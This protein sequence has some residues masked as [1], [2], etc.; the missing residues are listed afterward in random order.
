MCMRGIVHCFVD[1]DLKSTCSFLS[2]QKLFLNH[3]K[4]PLCICCNYFGCF[5]LFC[6]V[7]HNKAASYQIN[8]CDWLSENMSSS[9]HWW[10]IS[11]S[12]ALIFLSEHFILTQKILKD[13]IL[14]KK[15]GSLSDNSMKMCAFFFLLT[16]EVHNSP[17]NRHCV[18]ALPRDD[19]RRLWKSCIAWVHNRKL[20]T[21]W[22]V[23]VL[24]NSLLMGE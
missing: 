14:L 16:T 9:P 24:I 2:L 4:R 18:P 19:R 3:L 20:K 15:K 6:S 10:Q 22:L 5:F 8:C 13:N 7:Y 11:S 17:Q 21:F 23:W 1:K 12:K